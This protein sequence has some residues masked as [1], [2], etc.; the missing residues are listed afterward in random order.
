[1]SSIDNIKSNLKETIA[2]GGDEKTVSQLARKLKSLNK[3][4][5]YVNK[6]KY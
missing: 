2:K 5:G 3:K 6:Q 1:M 4:D